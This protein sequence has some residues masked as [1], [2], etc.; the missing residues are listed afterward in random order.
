VSSTHITE[1][2]P[3]FDKMPDWAR[4]AFEDGQYFNVV[5]EKVKRLEELETKFAKIR[6]LKSKR[7]SM[8]IALHG[9]GYGS[10]HQYI[11]EAKIKEIVGEQPDE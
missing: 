2:I 8:F 9:Y 11:D 4:E 5:A 7:L 1:I 3:D 10:N 6:A